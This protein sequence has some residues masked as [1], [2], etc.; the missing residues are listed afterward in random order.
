[1]FDNH[2][3]RSAPRTVLLL[4]RST[5][6][7]RTNEGFM[8]H[9]FI[10]GLYGRSFDSPASIRPHGDIGSRRCE[11]ERWADC[12]CVGRERATIFARKETVLEFL[13]ES[14]RHRAR[15]CVVASVF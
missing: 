1:M 4:L 6:Q 15:H 12:H 8:R 2:I 5:H 11:T 14:T 10:Q 13:V 3:D 9:R 7:T